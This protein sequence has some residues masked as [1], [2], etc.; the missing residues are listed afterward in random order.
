MR[1]RRG[2]PFEEDVDLAEGDPVDAA[3]AVDPDRA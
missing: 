2:N 1:G 3:A